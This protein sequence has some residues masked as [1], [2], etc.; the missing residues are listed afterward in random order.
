MKR[1]NVVVAGL[2]AGISLAVAA[3]VHAQPFGGMGHGFGPGMSLGPGQGSMAGVDPTGI[4]DSRLADL[5]TLL[6]I[7]TTQEAAWEAFVNAAKQQAAG[8]QAM[9]AQMLAG[10]GTAPER[11]GQRASAM[12]QRAQ[13]MA[14][15]TGAFDALYAVLTPEQKTVADQ[16]FGMMGHRG[17]M[18]FGP[19]A[20]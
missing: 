11:M 15:T 20:G 12:Q 4:I 2:V 6:K 18:R 19:R 13:A 7:T 16:H 3:F 1:M 17:M 8:M 10:T 5:K 9:R 14:T